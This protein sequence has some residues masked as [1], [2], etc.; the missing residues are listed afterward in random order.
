MTLRPLTP[1]LRLQSELAGD[2]LAL[3][4]WALKRKPPFKSRIPKPLRAAHQLL[5]AHAIFLSRLG[6]PPST[7]R[8]P[9]EFS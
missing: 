2:F 3:S 8:S 7:P 1:D 9:G 6:L 4:R 5:Y